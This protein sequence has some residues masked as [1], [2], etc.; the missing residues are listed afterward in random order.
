MLLGILDD[1]LTVCT[2][3]FGLG[4]FLGVMTESTRSKCGEGT[5]PP[6]FLSDDAATNRMG[7]QREVSV[8]C[9]RGKK[10]RSYLQILATSLRMGV[11]VWADI[12]IKDA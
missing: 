7:Q 10:F 2:D 6:L 4:G 8:V 3:R 1:G 12:N 9:R 11:H 5:E